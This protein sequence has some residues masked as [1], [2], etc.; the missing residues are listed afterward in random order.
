MF[1]EAVDILGTLTK[2]LETRVRSPVLEPALDGK[3]D[4]GRIR[5]F[6]LEEPGEE[7]KTESWFGLTI[8]LSGWE[9]S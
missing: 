8:E 9:E 7:L 2:V 3:E 6:G 4:L 5:R 1:E